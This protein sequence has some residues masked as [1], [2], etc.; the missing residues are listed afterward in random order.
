MVDR[1]EGA[2]VDGGQKR[3]DVPSEAF[4]LVLVVNGLTEGK[5]KASGLLE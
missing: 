5:V 2:R 3:P 1:S 4:S